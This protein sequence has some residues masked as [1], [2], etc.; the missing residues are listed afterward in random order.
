M[1]RK[2]D[3]KYILIINLVVTV[4]GGGVV[5][6]SINLL[7]SVMRILTEAIGTGLIATGLVNFFDKFFVEAQ[8]ETDIDIVSMRRARPDRAIYG[9]KY[10]AEKVDILGVSLADVL[11]EISRDSRHEMVERVLKQSTRFRL[12]FIHPDSSFLIQRAAEDHISW[13]ELHDRQVKSVEMAV[14]FYRLLLEAYNREDKADT[15][16]T[17]NVGSVEICLI[18]TCPY[19]SLFRADNSMYWGLYTA[20]KTGEE[21]PLFFSKKM[22]REGMFE[23]LKDHFYGL[24]PKE[25]AEN[26]Y[27]LKMII[28][29]QPPI[30]NRS[31]ANQ[32]LGVQKVDELLN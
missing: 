4:I 7:E 21:T 28:K 9:L 30:L 14:K 27:L 17:S 1:T 11:K 23:I 22:D 3:R 24:L 6:L 19:I 5:I 25:K 31:L 8:E 15:L 20:H 2:F 10:K 12:L 18:N 13:D 26:P 32:I 29:D 16:R